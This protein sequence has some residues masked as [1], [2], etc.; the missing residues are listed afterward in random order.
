M[1]AGGHAKVVIDAALASGWDLTQIC[2]LD[3]APERAGA[4]ILGLRIAT[5]AVP[6]ALGALF[7]VAIGNSDARGGLHDRAVRNGGS[8]ATIIHPRAVISPSATI[9]A[10]SFVAAGAVVG[11]DGSCGIGTILNHASIIDH[12]CRVGDFCHIAPGATLGGEVVIE[13]HVLVGASAV[14]LPGLKVGRGATIGAGAVVTQNV[15]PGQVWVGAP[16][17]EKGDRRGG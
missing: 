14:V 8:P 16:A 13:N 9:G 2:V 7:H 4:T 15:P 10:G 12:D 3:D 17:R 6:D 1:G 11:P 5:P